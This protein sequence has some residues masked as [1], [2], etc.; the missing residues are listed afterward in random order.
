[1]FTI[2]ADAKTKLIDFDITKAYFPMFFKKNEKLVEEILKFMEVDKKEY[3]LKKDEWLSFFDFI[4]Q[5][6]NTFPN[7]YDLATAWTLLLDEYY[8]KYAKAHNIPLPE[9][10]GE[11]ED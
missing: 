2:N 1:M 3:K 10:Y 5:L 7:G 11:E 9:G 8:I 4:C 6:G